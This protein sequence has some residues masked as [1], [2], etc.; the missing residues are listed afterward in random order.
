MYSLLCFYVKFENYRKTNL[1]E[2]ACEC[3]H[4]W[5]QTVFLATVPATTGKFLQKEHI[6]VDIEV[7]DREIKIYQDKDR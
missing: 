5:S 7:L 1:V 4:I 3:N 6:A 2:P